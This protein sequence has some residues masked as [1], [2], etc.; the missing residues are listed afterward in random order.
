MHGALEQT[1]P[2][3]G[4]QVLPQQVDHHHTWGQSLV[5]ITAEL[6]CSDAEVQF[7]LL[8]PVEEEEHLLGVAS[9]TTQEWM[10]PE[11]VVL[12]AHQVS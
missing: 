3:L 10:L 7:D 5:W 1:A 8:H 4:Q 11:V 6:R 9:F 2:D 12:P